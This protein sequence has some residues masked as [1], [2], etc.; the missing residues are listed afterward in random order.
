MERMGRANL[1]VDRI[2]HFAL[3][4]TIQEVLEIRKKLKTSELRGKLRKISK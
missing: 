1:L 3:L 2:D 4:C